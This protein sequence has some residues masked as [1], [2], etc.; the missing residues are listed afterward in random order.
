MGLNNN[1]LFIEQQLANERSPRYVRPFN[2][3]HP[4]YRFLQGYCF[5]YHAL[6]MFYWIDSA[7]R[8]SGIKSVQLP[9][10]VEKI[11]W[12]CFCGCKSLC[13][14]VFEPNSE[15]KEIGDEHGEKSYPLMN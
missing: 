6:N 8:D 2:L 3:L 10:G 13:E 12:H 9:S 1:L 15:L 11:G 14:I 4:D 7:F 5:P